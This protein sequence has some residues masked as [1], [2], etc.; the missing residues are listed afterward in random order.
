MKTSRISQL[1]LV[2]RLFLVPATAADLTGRVVLVGVPPPESR[3]DLGR[4]PAL[5][6]KHPDGLMTRRYQ[7]DATG[8][9]QG[10][11]VYLKGD[12]KHADAKP[13]ETP[14]VLDHQD[15]WFAPHV[16]GLRVGQELQLLYPKGA[17]IQ[18]DC[19]E[20]PGFM[21]AFHHARSFSKPEVGIRMKCHCHP[22]NYG[23]VGVFDHPY[24]AVTDTKGNYRI[25]GVPTGRHIVEAWHPKAGTTSSAIA[26]DGSASCDLY[27]VVKTN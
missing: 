1:I 17:V 20:Q 25:T 22:F 8:G 11:L 4:F 24:F 5:T 19:K 13:P 27:L 26:V 2:M 21:V 10:V 18:A 23:Y 15:G 6:Q 7:T 16:M 3:I 12:F 9:L 14:L